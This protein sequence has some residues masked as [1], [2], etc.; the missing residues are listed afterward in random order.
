MAFGEHPP[1]TIW[2]F[3][4]IQEMFRKY[5]SHTPGP[6]RHPVS[7]INTKISIEA[8]VNVYPARSRV[9]SAA[10]LDAQTTGPT[11]LDRPFSERNVSDLI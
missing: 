11:L 1:D 3:E 2:V 6:E 7:K 5:E 4:M 9:V 10:N 8:A